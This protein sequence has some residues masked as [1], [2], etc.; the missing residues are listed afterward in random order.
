M[1]KCI[2][3]I[4]IFTLTACQNNTI[5]DSEE[6]QSQ[7]QRNQ[8]QEQIYEIINEK[9]IVGKGTEWE[10]NGLLTLPKDIE[11]KIPAVV[12]V[13]GSGPQDMNETVYE[14]KP[15]LEIAEYLTTNGI[16]VIRYDKRTFTH[17][18]KMAQQFG[19]S[20]TMYE[21]TIEDAILATKIL[22][23]DQRIDE[24][25]VY[26]LGHSL[27]GSLAPRI[28]ASGGDYAGLILFAGTPRSL[29]EVI[30]DQQVLYYTET[31][32]EGEELNAILSSADSSVEQQITG[33]LNMIDE[34]AK[35]IDAGSG[36]SLYY[37]KDN[38]INLTE[39]YIK[40]ITVPFLV[41]H[42]DNDFQVFTDKDFAMYKELLSNHSNVTFK[43][44]EGL[45]HFFMPSTVTRSID[46]QDEYK[47]KF[48]ID[49]QV[50]QDIVTWIKAN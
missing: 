19:G 39:K 2:I 31:M 43:L 3:S 11:G 21:E 24:N 46:I 48:N 29:I 50:L 41:M 14:N 45:N 13:H 47:T 16:A 34:E 15:F 20:L 36:I 25:R 30:A 27:G 9:I 38:L 32:E 12:L 1:K 26:I 10:L 37:Y 4:L 22:K 6:E 33:I 28:H 23:S 42:A 5:K 35:N 17:W 7:E 49:K 40:D 8:E 18:A 44:Y